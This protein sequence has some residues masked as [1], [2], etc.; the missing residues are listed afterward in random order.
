MSV[1]GVLAWI[2]FG[3]LAGAVAR[4]V[5]PGKHPRGCI[6]TIA[7][8]ISG[9]VVGGLI[10]QTLFEKHVKWGFSLR[11]FGLAVLGAVVVLLVLQALA[12]RRHRD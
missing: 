1:L 6:V 4:M 7:V 3:F 11:P 10:G 9:A 8:G 12:G 2:L 5:T